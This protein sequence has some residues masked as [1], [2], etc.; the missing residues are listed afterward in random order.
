M[1]EKIYADYKA[2]VYSILKKKCDKGVNFGRVKKKM[3]KAEIWGLFKGYW[4]HNAPKEMTKYLWHNLL[5]DIAKYFAHEISDKFQDQNA[6]NWTRF[7]IDEFLKF[8][9]CNNLQL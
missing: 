9:V 2:H 8:T 3:N 6:R 7:Q 5:R 1:P 4:F